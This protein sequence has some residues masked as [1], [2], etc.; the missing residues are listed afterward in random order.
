MKVC[1]DIRT[2]ADV[3]HLFKSGLISHSD[4]K[5]LLAQLATNEYVHGSIERGHESS[6]AT[7]VLSPMDTNHDAFIVLPNTDAKA[8][9]LTAI[10]VTDFDWEPPLIQINKREL[11]TQPHQPRIKRRPV[12]EKALVNGIHHW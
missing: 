4:A 1:L 11:N 12:F 5:S 2:A 10:P 6:E 7:I 9:V 3:M 8:F